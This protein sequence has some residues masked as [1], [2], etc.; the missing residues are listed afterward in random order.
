[1]GQSA[2]QSQEPAEPRVR[3]LGHAAKRRG[4]GKGSV[5][6]GAANSCWAGSVSL[7]YS[8][9]QQAP[10]AYSVQQAVDDWLGSGLDGRPAATAPSTG[11][12]SSPFS[13]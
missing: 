6:F 4:H 13:S 2:R 9:R 12:S 11:T 8:P 10:A 5:Y 7:G 1:M 3:L